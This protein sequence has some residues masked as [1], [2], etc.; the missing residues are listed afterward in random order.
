MLP[1]TAN[2]Y[3]AAQLTVSDITDEHLLKRK[4]AGI[5][6][7]QVEKLSLPDILNPESQTL[8]LVGIP[9][10]LQL[11]FLL[12][13]RALIDRS[14]G[15]PIKNE[16]QQSLDITRAI[17]Y[18]R[19]D[20]A[21]QFHRYHDTCRWNLA[22][23]TALLAHLNTDV[24]TLP[25]STPQPPHLDKS[26]LVLVPEGHN[27]HIPPAA[28]RF[29]HSYLAAVMENHNTPNVFTARETFIRRWKSGVWDVY[30]TFAS[31][32]KK[33]LKKEL[34]RLNK[35][36]ET[37]LDLARTGI[38]SNG[39]TREDYTQRVA[40]FVGCI[41]PGRK[42]QGLPLKTL[43]DV[44]LDVS[45]ETP[46]AGDKVAADVKALAKQKGELLEALR[47]PLEEREWRDEHQDE[48]VSEVT[49]LRIAVDA[50]K[51]VEPA[52][53]LKVLLQLFP[54]GYVEKNEG[55]TREVTGR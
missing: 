27:H 37:E 33:L 25:S 30:T 1:L 32:M 2:T 15:T 10:D 6:H 24:R 23:Y 12:R 47:V 50:V 20:E 22:L 49:N 21:H 40:P 39:M 9:Q 13:N 26:R 29:M 55:G 44:P 8:N 3:T 18:Y 11:A 53:M 38:G 31:S 41:I 51:T 42:D 34:R 46:E 43:W 54:V 35:A 48:G 52:D 17:Y 19:L 45:S 36:W 16:E 7:P 14:A 28:R 4:L 5:P